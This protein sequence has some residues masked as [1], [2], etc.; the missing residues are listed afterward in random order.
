MSRD[1][2]GA[3]PT[4]LRLSQIASSGIT[5]KLLL[6]CC[7]APC[8]SYVL[9]YLSPFF[10]VTLFFCNPNID[11]REEYEKR[12][13]MLDR[14][15]IL[16]GYPNKADIIICDYI[17]NVFQATAAPLTN[18][19]EGGARCRA[20]FEIRLGET[21]KYAKEYKYDFFATTL[22][23][24]PHKNANLLNEIGTKMAGEHGIE[25]LEADFKKRGGYQRSVELSK[26]YGLY[27][28]TYCGCRIT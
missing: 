1:Y 18:E 16:S 4:D 17:P 25:F 8:T 11:T 23:V 22:S 13:E 12:A 9:E 24:S 15:P 6:H 14:L 19:P 28:Q 5:P 26:Q 2:H 21:A 3:L 7:C 10:T 20:C 27:R